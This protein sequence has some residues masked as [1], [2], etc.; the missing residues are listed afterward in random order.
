MSRSLTIPRRFNGPP[1]SGNGGWACGRVAAEADG[2]VA[3][4]LR[5]PPP[6]ERAL[7]I[8]ETSGGVEVYDQDTLVAR[9]VSIDDPPLLVVPEEVS[10]E[11]ASAASEHYPGLDEHAFPGCFVCGPDREAGDGLRIFPGPVEGTDLWAGTWT[12]D[13]S[14]SDDGVTVASEQMWAALDCPSGWPGIRGSEVI[15]LARM[16]VT[17]TEPAPVGEPLVVMG[18]QTGTNGRKVSSAAA[19]TTRDGTVLGRSQSL[20]I[21]LRD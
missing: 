1:D 21:A 11:Q 15:V 10:W 7:A 12:P 9:A 17:L 16:A 4:E 2:P 6:L 18:W 20:W 13:E 8:R 5:A 14:N 19:I 3:V